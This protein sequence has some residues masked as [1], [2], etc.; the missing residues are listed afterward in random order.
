MADF[1]WLKYDD[2]DVRIRQRMSS[3]IDGQLVRQKRTNG[4]LQAINLFL[5]RR[6]NLAC[7]HCQINGVGSARDPDFDISTVKQ[8]VQSAIPY[9]LEK[10]KISG[11]EPLTR[12]DSF[13]ILRWLD[14]LG[15]EIALET[16]ATLF[17]EDS[18][19]SLE[20][21]HKL[22]VFVSL[23]DVN[24]EMHDR[25]RGVRG[26][27]RKTLE[28]LR[29]LGRSEVQT[30]VTTTA[31]RFNYSRLR[32]IVDSILG[33]GIKKH[34]T[35]INI[36]P[37]G[38]ARQHPENALTMGEIEVLISDLLVS[39]HF[40]TGRAYATLP[41]ALTPVNMIQDFFGCGWGE[42]IV[43]V[44]STG[45]ITMC[46]PSYDDQRMI[47]GNIFVQDFIEIWEKSL[48]LKRLR[49]VAAG[50]V[51]GVCGNCIFYRV[52]R[53]WCRLSSYA[54]YDVIDAP[55]PLCQEVYNRGGFPRYALQQPMIDC[56][57]GKEVIRSTRHSGS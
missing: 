25:F 56:A 57:Y 1:K 52:C 32:E 42:S 22:T 15:L 3:L 13:D 29:G 6:C 14:D 45:D 41:P 53:G 21:L 38:R 36:H 51:N 11:G 18:V 2:D 12:S 10:V 55:Y 46:G 50:K 27:H 37:L 17:D 24:P 33:W 28:A 47:A 19:R 48:L 49:D 16:N 7:E 5:T 8:V 39:S 26:S 43:G 44:L 20:S 34:R 35:L 54:H 40:Q 30:V 9:G 23:D 31:N 4:K